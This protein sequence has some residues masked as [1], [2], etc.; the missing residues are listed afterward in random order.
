V[1]E[2]NI[3]LRDASLYRLSQYSASAPQHAIA[4]T[5]SPAIPVVA[6]T[7]LTAGAAAVTGVHGNSGT[8][9]ITLL[10]AL[11]F[12]SVGRA[13]GMPLGIEKKKPDSD[14]EPLLAD[15]VSADNTYFRVDPDMHTP[16]TKWMHLKRENLTY[17][18]E[19][20]RTQFDHGFFEDA[21]EALTNLSYSPR[22]TI[23]WMT[24]PF[25]CTTEP[26]KTDMAINF[27][28]SSGKSIKKTKTPHTGQC[29]P[30]KKY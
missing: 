29:T 1:Q 7:A 30:S 12:L 26:R 2:S 24:A 4:S 25:L 20:L 8:S 27:I 13:T 28:P 10:V 19:F 23:I 3:E 18:A 15:A 14:I 22:G 16:H 5:T 21:L 17:V 9:A 11:I 6:L